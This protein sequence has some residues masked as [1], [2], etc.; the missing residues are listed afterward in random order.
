MAGHSAVPA[1]ERAE[2][3]AH[4][5]DGRRPGGL[6][7][8]CGTVDGATGRAVGLWHD[9]ALPACRQQGRAGDVHA[10][11]GPRPPAPAHGW[12]GLVWRSY[13]LGLRAAGCLPPASVGAA[14]RVGGSARGSGPT[15]MAGRRPRRPRRY[16]AGRARQAGRRDGALEIEAGHVDGPDYPGLLRQ[17]LD[18]DRFPALAAAVDAGVFDDADN[19]HLGEFRS[20][21]EQLVDGIAARV[22]AVSG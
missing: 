13:R 6:G 15:G 2:P 4:R 14:G 20:G 8:A 22:E 21:L 7:R 19:D 3:G 16:R 1:V 18:A 12:S 5:R 17:V 11:D 9:V 10:L